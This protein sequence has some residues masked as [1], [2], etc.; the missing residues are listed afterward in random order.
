MILGKE[1]RRLEKSWD[2]EAITPLLKAFD[3]YFY[4]EAMAVH[5]LGMLGISLHMETIFG[6]LGVC[7]Q[8][9]SN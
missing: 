6:Q 5:F 8:E 2:S 1:R 3:G 9:E 4:G 7:R